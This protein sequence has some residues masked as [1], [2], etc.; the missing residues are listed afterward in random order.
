MPP[1]IR[2]ADWDGRELAYHAIIRI[3]GCAVRAWLDLRV[4]GAGRIPRD[5]PLLLAANHVSFVDPVVLAVVCYGQG[6]KVRFLTLSD[7]FARPALGWILRT[8][9]MI[10][11][12]RG[13]GVQRMV[14]A[15]CDALDAGQ[16][17]LVYPEGRIIR[18]GRSPARPGAGL[19]ALRTTSPV[20]PLCS[21]GLRSLG[22]GHLPRLRQDAAVVVGAPVDLS[23]WRDRVDRQAQMAVSEAMLDAVYDLEPL[24]MRIA[25]ADS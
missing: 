19:L 14:D 18:G 17:V 23:P 9:R 13:G 2:S 25:H 7:L 6:R 5:G 16:T 24:A 1:E 21:Y 20:V 15:A 4:V 10:P 12:V 3:L 22:G 8:G 11:V